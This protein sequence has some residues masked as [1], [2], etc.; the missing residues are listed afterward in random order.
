MRRLTMD[1]TRGPAREESVKRLEAQL[2]VSL[3]EDYRLFLLQ[4]DGGCPSEENDYYPTY[5]GEFGGVYVSDFFP[6]EAQS[7]Y[8]NAFAFIC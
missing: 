6:I 2:G 4:Y 3:P 8:D 1:Y 5:L 7:P